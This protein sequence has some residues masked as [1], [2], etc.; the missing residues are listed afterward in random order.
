VSEQN[1]PTLEE[2]IP[3]DVPAEIAALSAAL[4]D[5][6][7]AETLAEKLTGDEF[8]TPKHRSVFIGIQELVRQKKPVDVVTLHS[9]LE[10]LNLIAQAQGRPFLEELASA[11]SVPANV[12][13]YVKRVRDTY[14]ERR[15]MK[16]GQRIAGAALR[17]EKTLD[18]Q[19]E[20]AER[21]VF[22]IRRRQDEGGFRPI[23]VAVAKASENIERA[24]TLGTGIT[25]IPTGFPTLDEMLGGLQKSQMTVIAGRPGMGK[26]A[27]GL[28]IARTAAK[29]GHVVGVVSLEMKEGVAGLRLLSAETEIDSNRMRTGKLGE[30]GDEWATIV[31]ALTDISELPI[32]I[33]DQPRLTFGQLRSRARRLKV[34]EGLD[35]L[36]VDYLQLVLSV[37]RDTRDQEVAALTGNLVELFRELDVAGVVLS[38]LSRMVE[39]RED[40]RPM[41]SDLRESGMIEAAADAVIFPYCPTYYDHDKLKQSMAAS[42]DNPAHGEEAQ[43]FLEKHRHGPTGAIDVVFRRR[44]ASFYERQGSEVFDDD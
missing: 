29:A 26:S 10:R 20:E 41:L 24:H 6:E 19:L 18:E 13:E 11:T 28:D 12:D 43:F 31:Q 35:V 9:E 30:E 40:K 16:L 7:A 17:H 14:D 37:Q 1:G 5:G 32:F 25:G 4:K 8:Y 44:L 36:V 23:S 3:Q 15:L 33:D 27:L 42:K 38:Q 34:D 22:K 21:E 39:K 2:I